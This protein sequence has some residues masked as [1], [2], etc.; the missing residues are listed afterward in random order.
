[1]GSV[2]ICAAEKKFRPE[3]ATTGQ[4]GV[5]GRVLRMSLRTSEGTAT[6]TT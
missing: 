4:L 1:M 3:D 5:V 6:H 2:T